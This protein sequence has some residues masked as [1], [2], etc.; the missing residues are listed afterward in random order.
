MLKYTSLAWNSSRANTTQLLSKMTFPIR[1]RST[2]CGVPPHPIWRA[3]RCVQDLLPDLRRLA[4][5]DLPTMKA[6]SHLRGLIPAWDSTA[7]VKGAKALKFLK[8]SVDFIDAGSCPTRMR[9]GSFLG[10]RN[11]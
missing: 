9:E 4:E 10:L 3:M 5:C 8:S 6:E 11:Q 2:I 7:E 1:R